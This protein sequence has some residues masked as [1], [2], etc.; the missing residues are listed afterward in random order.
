M[1][2]ALGEAPRV[3]GRGV[4]ALVGE[5]KG[6][7]A[8]L[9]VPPVDGDDGVVPGHP[10]VRADLPQVRKVGVGLLGFQGFQWSRF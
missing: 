2:A 8:V 4:V 3:P 9:V 6:D 7:V 1:P 10:Y 5:L